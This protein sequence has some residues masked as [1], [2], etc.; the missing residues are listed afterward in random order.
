MRVFIAKA[1]GPLVDSV[2]AAVKRKH[3]GNDAVLEAYK[4]VQTKEVKRIRIEEYRPLAL[5]VRR[6][7]YAAKQRPL[8]AGLRPA[9]LAGAVRQ[10]DV[11]RTC[12]R[13]LEDLYNLDMQYRGALSVNDERAKLPEE[14]GAS[15]SELEPFICK[16]ESSEDKEDD[17][18]GHAAE[19]TLAELQERAVLLR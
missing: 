17:A 1:K 2:G 5:N 14:K 19:N 8:E 12:V 10:E 15:D 11:E 6:N 18:V 16:D 4:T 7:D 9:P 13:M 3:G